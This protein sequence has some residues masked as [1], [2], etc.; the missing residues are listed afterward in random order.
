MAG[1]AVA[2]AVIAVLAWPQLDLRVERLSH[3][4]DEVERRM[5]LHR[6]VERA[7]DEA[8]G[9]DAVNRFGPAS[10]NRSL[11]TRLAWE[12]GRPIDEIETARG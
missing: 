11:H 7:L 8:G 4:A 9:A 5:A 12:L 6:D 10:V 3:E 1:A 2:A